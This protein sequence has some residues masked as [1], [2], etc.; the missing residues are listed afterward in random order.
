MD[1]TE[2]FTWEDMPT[3]DADTGQLTAAG[4]IPMI[5]VFSMSAI[6]LDAMFHFVQSTIRML[7]NHETIFITGYPLT[8]LFHRS[9]NWLTSHR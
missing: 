3:T 7:T 6:I 5:N 9:M 8:G 4:W 1:L 2:S